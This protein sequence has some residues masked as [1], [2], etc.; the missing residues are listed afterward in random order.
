MALITCPECGREISNQA[1]TCQGCGAPAHKVVPAQIVPVSSA[2]RQ[3]LIAIVALV[4]IAVVTLAVFALLPAPNRGP[5]V[6]DVQSKER[7]AVRFCWE[8][9]AK[10]K[11]DPRLDRSTLGFVYTVCEK[12]QNDYRAKWGRDP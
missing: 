9:Y 7:N 11:D 3:I 2:G 12:K 4:G 6:G 1:A 10:K 8:D 5:T